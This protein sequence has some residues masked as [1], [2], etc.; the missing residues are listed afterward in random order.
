MV[1][2]N[3]MTE[4][5]ARLSSFSNIITKALG[6]RPQAAV[7]VEKI[8]YRAGDRFILCSDGIWNCEP[9][10]EIIKMFNASKRPDEALR[11]LTERVNA[12]GIQNGES[13]D[14][15]TAI[16]VDMKKDSIY[17]Y[18]YMRRI[19]DALSEQIRLIKKKK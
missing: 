1:A 17:Q 10:P 4:E 16:V 14:N 18:S 2:K 19:K 6:I 3:L 11:Y 15:L 5:Q 8:P 7:Q 12:I 13:H 9:E